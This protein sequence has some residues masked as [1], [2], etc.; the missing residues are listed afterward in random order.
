MGRGLTLLISIKGLNL[1]SCYNGRELN[2]GVPLLE[3]LFSFGLACRLP[4]FLIRGEIFQ[5]GTRMLDFTK[6]GGNEQ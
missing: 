3:S 2:A 4:V 6:E 5:N 1:F